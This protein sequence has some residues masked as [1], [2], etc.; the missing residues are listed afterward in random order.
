MFIYQ[1]SEQE[2]NTF[3]IITFSAKKWMKI[4]LENKNSGSWTC[5]F[6][7]FLCMSL[8]ALQ[9]NMKQMRHTNSCIFHVLLSAPKCLH[10]LSA[11]QTNIPHGSHGTKSNFP[12]TRATTD[13]PADPTEFLWMS[14]MCNQTPNTKQPKPPTHTRTCTRIQRGTHLIW[15][16]VCVLAIITNT[17]DATVPSQHRARTLTHGKYFNITMVYTCASVRQTPTNPPEPWWSSS[18]GWWTPQRNRPPRTHPPPHTSTF[19]LSELGRPFTGGSWCGA[20]TGPQQYYSETSTVTAS[21]KVSVSVCTRESGSVRRCGRIRCKSV[22][23]CSRAHAYIVCYPTG[24]GLT[25]VVP[26][27]SGGAWSEWWSCTII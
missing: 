7:P 12:E 5:V 18:T 8:P 26:V 19:Q 17:S 15:I 21:V 2:R 13:R 3:C 14:P 1:K 23:A 9:C 22:L 16:N 24:L 25:L 20:A 11:N 4:N 27:W 10:V 6:T